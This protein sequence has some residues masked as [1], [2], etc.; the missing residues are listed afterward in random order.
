MPSVLDDLRQ[1][2]GVDVK[3]GLRVG[4]DVSHLAKMTDKPVGAERGDR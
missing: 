3:A 2:C 1:M 4:C